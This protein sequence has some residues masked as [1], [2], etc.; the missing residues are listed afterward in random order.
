MSGE[1]GI[2][3]KSHKQQKRRKPWRGNK[4][5][6]QLVPNRRKDCV[7]TGFTDM[8]RKRRQ[9]FFTPVFDQQAFLRACH[10]CKIIK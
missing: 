2:E 6:P 9:S 7:P 3:E 1:G 5:E 4:Q 8:K 10:R